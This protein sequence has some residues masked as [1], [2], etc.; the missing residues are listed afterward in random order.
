MGYS[1]IPRYSASANQL[2]VILLWVCTFIDYIV[3]TIS[4]KII[5]AL[6]NLD[7]YTQII[8]DIKYGLIWAMKNVRYR[9]LN[10]T[11]SGDTCEFT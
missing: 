8:I 3:R 10:G 4:D 1:A 7:K 2:R 6:E 5:D 11:H 9:Y